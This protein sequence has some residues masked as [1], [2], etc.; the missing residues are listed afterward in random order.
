MATPAGA[1]AQATVQLAARPTAASSACD[2]R[3]VTSVVVRTAPAERLSVPSP[4][5][6]LETAVDALQSTTRPD[7]VTRMLLLAPG[8]V[9]SAARLDEAERVLRGQR[10][11]R[12]V[13]IVPVEDSA[14]VRLE[15]ETQDEANLVASPF[16]QGA[17]P[18]MRGGRFGALNL[19]GSARVGEVEWRDGG[20]YANAMGVRYVDR[21]FAGRLQELSLLARQNLDGYLLH[22]GLTRPIWSD[23]QHVAYASSF[24]R[25]YGYAPL[26]RPGEALTSV[27][28]RQSSTVLG[29]MWRSTSPGAR[30][31]LGSAVTTAT[32]D[33][34]GTLMRPSLAG[35]VADSGTPIDVGYRQQRVARMNVLA[36]VDRS[37]YLLAQ[38]L[39]ALTAPQDI[40]VGGQLSVQVGQAVPVGM[41]RDRDRYVA[42]DG[43]LGAGVASAFVTTSVR[44]E[45]RRALGASAWD[46]VVAS[47]RT[48]AYLQPTN[49]L[50]TTFTAT[51]SAGQQVQ[52]PFQLSLADFDGGV[53]GYRSSAWSGARRLV[54]QAEQRVTFAANEHRLRLPYDVGVALVAQAGRLWRDTQVAYAVDTPW[55]PSV[56]VALMASP[57]GA[58]RMWRLDIATP[59][60]TDPLRRFE[61][62]LTTS[63]RTRSAG[64]EPRDVAAGRESTRL[65]DLFG[66]R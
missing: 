35:F 36:G 56:G 24:E 48:A 66:W 6:F 19:G 5:R 29:A 39:D 43:Y 47:A 38:G 20:G 2:G 12:R 17:A 65:S 49:A 59:V 16:V 62:R 58:R 26:R 3:V 31:M 41:L 1:R 25:S 37:H 21:V 61:V 64:R 53:L 33:A 9:C 55:Q 60:G 7:V 32:L 46:G 51:A 40:R 30:I 63:D 11:F 52:A 22:A 42:L 27:P 54:L 10:L 13:E 23:A 8:D 15:V 50:T 34:T 4:L 28:V 14:G 44:A 45:A 57:P 18:Q